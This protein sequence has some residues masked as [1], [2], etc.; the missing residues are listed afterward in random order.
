M[1]K[2]ADTIVAAVDIPFLHIADATAQAVKIADHSTVGLLATAYTMEQ[3]FYIGRLRD[4]HGLNILVPD[5]PDRHVIHDTIYNEL[6]LGVI[7]DDSR[8]AYRE[9]INTLV[10]RG[11]TGVLL[12]CTEISLLIGPSD[13]EVP[14]FDTTRLHAYSAVDLALQT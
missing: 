1:H 12:G 6:C 10:R 5:K 11:A 8:T 14:L 2:V 13:A 4:Q 3:D 9:I 7:S